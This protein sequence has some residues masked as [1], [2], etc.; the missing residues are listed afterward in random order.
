MSQDSKKSAYSLLASI[1]IGAFLAKAFWVYLE[2]KTL[3]KSGV[4]KEQK[5]AYKNLYYRYSLASKKDKPKIVKKDN[6]KVNKPKPK[7]K[8]QQIKNFVLKGIY[9][10]NKQKFI[11]ISYKNKTTFLNLGEELE[12]YKLTKILPK[13]AIFTRDNNEY[14]LKLFK[15]KK[16]KN[17]Q[18]GKK[19]NNTT[20]KQTTTKKVSTKQDVVKE[21]DVTIISKS[22]FDKYRTNIS[23]LRKEI[24][25]VPVMEGK[26]LK[27]FRVSYI[28]KG[29]VF[30]KSGVKRG[31][32]ITAI[33]GEEITDFSVPINF[34]N[35]LNSITSATL[36]IKRG[37]EY[38]ELEYEVR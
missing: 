9:I 29:S 16:D 28:K 19:A 2:F 22:L 11:V 38:K 25:A 34:F 27:G 10:D 31:D 3:P 1:A 6:S 5:S 36:T 7:P 18:S 12:G 24:N 4:E 37:N 17:I 15:E 14:E 20:H 35:N 8:P 32:I 30:E 33:N 23:A 26:K 13:S 21:G